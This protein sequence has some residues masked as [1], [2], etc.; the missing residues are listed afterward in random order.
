MTIYSDPRWTP[1]RLPP[2]QSVK[3]RAAGLWQRVKIFVRTSQGRWF[4][5][6]I[7]IAAT[8]STASASLVLEDALPPGEEARV[9]SGERLWWLGVSVAFLVVLV[10]LRQRRTRTAGTLYY[11]RY[12][13]EWMSDW[14]VGDLEIVKRKYVDRRVIARWSRVTPVDG[15]LELVNDVTSMCDELQRS[16]NDD[17]ADTAFNLA[18]NLLLPVSLAVG[19]HLYQWDDLTLEELFSPKQTLSWRLDDTYDYWRFNTPSIRCDH[20]ANLDAQAVL[21]KVDLTGGAATLPP[22][23]F[24]SHYGVAV[25]ADRVGTAANSSPRRVTV[26]TRPPTYEP[27]V[28]D[29]K[30][31]VDAF[32]HPLAAV[33]TARRAIRLALHDNPDCL[34]VLALRVP[35]TVALGIGWALANDSRPPRDPRPSRCGVAGCLQQ[36]CLHPWSRLVLANHNQE[37]T[38]GDYHWARVMDVQPSADQIRELTERD[39]IA[40]HAELENLTPHEVT[41]M[42]NGTAFA[43]WPTTGVFARLDEDVSAPVPLETDQ[44]FIPVSQVRYAETVDGLPQQVSGTAYL[45]SRVLA[46][47]VPRDDLYFPL[48]EVRDVTG[49]IIGCRALGQFDHHH[50]ME[51]DD[52]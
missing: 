16:M 8:V 22:G 45:V 38:D 10:F 6:L 42:A 24:R 1:G 18:P 19:Q 48:G 51:A 14:R 39:S 2:H 26:T 46:A 33:E 13:Q 9:F 43:S 32:V 41:V 12:L 11:L 15:V 52:A 5:P 40:G 44:G 23:T 35:K 37:G 28:G 20:L 34:V 17:R 36:S 31:S 4:D 25:F 29:T 27:I 3:D 21:V 7:I 30:T 47:A 49:R 50:S